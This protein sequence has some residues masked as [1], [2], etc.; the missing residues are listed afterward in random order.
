MFPD[1]SVKFDRILQPKSQS[2]SAYI[3]I[4]EVEYFQKDF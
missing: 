4:P 1:F 2:T 3:S